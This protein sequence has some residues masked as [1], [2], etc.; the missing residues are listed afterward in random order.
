[1][2]NQ[3]INSIYEEFFKREYEEKFGV[4]EGEDRFQVRLAELVTVMARK[5]FYSN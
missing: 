2:I 1:M 3:E 5:V 4:E